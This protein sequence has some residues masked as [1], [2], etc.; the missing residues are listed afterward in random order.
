MVD[1]AYVVIP[2]LLAIGLMVLVIR[3]TGLSRPIVLGD[4]NLVAQSIDEHFE[5][6]TITRLV[7]SED[8]NGALVYLSGG[9]FLVLV[10]TLGDRLVVRALAANALNSLTGEGNALTIVLNDFTW[11]KM[12]LHFVDAAAREAEQKQINNAIQEI[13]YA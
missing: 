13:A 3:A 8:G 10:R 12:Q 5:G 7:R 11:P 6:A 2:S 4:D 9:P 1:L